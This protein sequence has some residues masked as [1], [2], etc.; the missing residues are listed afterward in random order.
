MRI[1]GRKRIAIL[2]TLQETTVHP[3][4]DC[5]LDAEPKPRYPNLSL[6]HGVPELK[7]VL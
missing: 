7:K 3:T 6:A 5:G 4:A 2:N 1:L